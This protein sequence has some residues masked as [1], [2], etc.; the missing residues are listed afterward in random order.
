MKVLWLLV[1]FTMV[2][3][4]FCISTFEDSV[5]ASIIQVSSMLAEDVLS[6]ET[7]RVHPNIHLLGINTLRYSILDLTNSIRDILI[8]KYA[9][10]Q[11]PMTTQQAYLIKLFELH[12]SDLPLPNIFTKSYI[13]RLELQL[14]EMKWHLS[15]AQSHLKPG[16]LNIRADHS[17]MLI[18]CARIVKGYV[19][20]YNSI[21]L[22]GEAPPPSYTS[23][24]TN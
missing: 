21:R 10:P 11:H 23:S 5:D 20:R 2:T 18:T 6:T 16:W 3:S 8:K 17:T 15:T 14:S 4:V 19:E 13:E 1:I 9:R 12:F 22:L 7:Y 24:N